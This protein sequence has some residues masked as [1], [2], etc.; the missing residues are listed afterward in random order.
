MRTLIAIILT[1]V[2]MSSCVGRTDPVS[3]YSPKVTQQSYHLSEAER[4]KIQ[5]GV[6]R[7]L[8]DPYSAMFGAMIASKGEGAAVYV[9]GYVNAK[10]S[11]GGYV[12]YKI[13]YGI[14]GVIDGKPWTFNVTGMGGTDVK[15][16]VA[17]QMC[18][19]WQIAI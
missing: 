19:R 10:N 7:S 8:K 14:L 11:F 4:S 15:D 1:S 12:G 13:F 2:A 5:E 17:R 16:S 9:C 6:R 18:Q 3:N